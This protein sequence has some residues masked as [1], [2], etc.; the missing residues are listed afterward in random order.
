MRVG[1]GVVVV[2]VTL[3]VMAYKLDLFHMEAPED[4]YSDM[5]AA[6]KEGMSWTDVADIKEPKKFV[7]YSANPDVGRLP[8]RAFE[9]ELIGNWIK[10]DKMHFGFIFVYAFGPDYVLEVHF[11]DSGAFEGT[12]DAFTMG[13]LLQTKKRR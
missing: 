6:V 2:L 5:K 7:K 1:F 11:D 9:R 8:P 10:E 3:I 12:S 13:D 4:Q